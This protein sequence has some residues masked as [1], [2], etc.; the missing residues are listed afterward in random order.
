MIFLDT[1]ICID[2]LHEDYNLSSFINIF[3]PGDRFAVT[4]LS[5]FELYMGFY[6]L[7]FG[8]SKISQANLAKE[9]E[10]IQE[11]VNSL[12]IFPLDEKASQEAAKIF[13]QLEA[14]GKELDPFDCMIA[15]IV[16]SN[17][18]SKILTRNARHFQRIRGI[19]VLKP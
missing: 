14:A 11:L 17:N 12:Y 10:N 5:L 19:K 4:S 15:S 18:Y 8:K 6:K 1:D 2:I 3:S 16:L 7:Q 9:R 13:R